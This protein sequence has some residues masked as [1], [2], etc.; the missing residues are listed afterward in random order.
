MKSAKQVGAY[1]VAFIVLLSGLLVIGAAALWLIYRGQPAFPVS[2]F[3]DAATEQNI[4]PIRWIR[5]ADVTDL[6]RGV[7]D[8]R[9]LLPL[10]PAPKYAEGP[11]GDALYQAMGDKFN[12]GVLDNARL[13]AQANRQ[14]LS[15]ALYQALRHRFPQNKLLL[16]EYTGVLGGFGKSREAADELIAAFRQF[17]NDAD[18]RLL[19]A[20]NLWYEGRLLP[21]DSIAGLALALDPQNHEARRLQETIRP[22][23]EPDLATAQRWYRERPRPAEQLMLARA[24]VRQQQYAQALPHYRAVALAA[25]GDSI[26]LEASS[27]AAAADS[28]TL[29]DELTAVY[30]TRHPND[31]SNRLRLARAFS[32]RQNYARS[33]E[34]FDDVITRTNDPGI[35]LEKA[36]VL[37]WAGREREAELELNTVLAALPRNVEALKLMGDVALYAGN[38]IRAL[39]YYGYASTIDPLYPGLTAALSNARQLAEMTRLAS[40]PQPL[41][42]GYSV[43]LQTYSDNQN[44]RWA[45]GQAY[46]TFRSGRNSFS[47]ALNQEVAQA[48]VTSAISTNPGFGGRIIAEIRPNDRLLVKLTTGAQ[49]FDAIGTFATFAAEVSIYDFLGTTATARF[50]HEPAMRRALTLLALHA[51]TTVN[52]GQVAISKTVGKSSFSAD[53][54]LE[55]FHSNVGGSSRWSANAAVDRAITPRLTAGASVSALTARQAPSSDNGQL[56]WAP[57]YFVQPT[58]NARYRAPISNVWSVTAGVSG[59]MGFVKERVSTQQRFARGAF[60]TAGASIELGYRNGPWDLMVGGNYGGSVGAGYKATTVQ[61]QGSYRVK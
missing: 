34:L 19:A 26:L 25:Q 31:V 40:L 32:W 33:L 29:L 38:S 30:L 10:P 12:R 1:P 13:A 52:A 36:N 54:Q 61:V 56:Y 24:F 50:T 11:P 60:P 46:R 42:E 27:A 20:Q 51:G 7:F 45:N 55:S 49:V 4:A 16:L 8:P 22:L 18:L 2:V 43:A 58:L 14:T 37:M 17:P 9:Q 21:A 15:I 6:P 47:L 48:P 35:R 57:E 53:A 44:F 28:V 3:G 41:P 5:P 23:A 39:K 59:G